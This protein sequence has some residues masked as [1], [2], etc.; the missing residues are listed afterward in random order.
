MSIDLAILSDNKFDPTIGC[1]TRW[2]LVVHDRHI[3]AIRT[4]GKCIG[5]PTAPRHQVV[6]NRIGLLGCQLVSTH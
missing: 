2:R 1:P 5:V 4:L 3:R 6:A